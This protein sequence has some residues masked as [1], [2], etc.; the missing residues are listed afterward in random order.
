MLTRSRLFSLALLVA[1]LSAFSL[2]L[3]M[4]RAAML[5][6]EAQC[7]AAMAEYRRSGPGM[8]EPVW[9]ICATGDLQGLPQSSFF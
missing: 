5:S 4:A 7:L 6:H 9:S 3:L 1:V 8:P 2:V